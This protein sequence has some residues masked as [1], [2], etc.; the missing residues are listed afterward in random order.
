MTKTSTKTGTNRTGLLTSPID[1]QRLKEG[2]DK[3]VPSSQ[4]G[5]QELTE[6]HHDI[7]SEWPTLGSVPPPGSIKGA[8]KAAV[9]ALKGHG[10]AVF[11]DRLGERLAFERT[12]ARL[13]QA[14]IDKLDVIG[15]VDGHSHILDGLQ[16]IRDEELKHFDL[17]RRAIERLGA[18]P[19]AMTP[20]ADAS[21]VLG[22]G[23]LQLAGDPRAD[24]QQCLQALLVAELGDNDGWALLVE[25]AEGMDQGDLAEEFRRALAE[26]EEHLA[27]VRS[28]LTRAVLEDA[29]VIAPGEPERPGA[30]V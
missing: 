24:L 18:D 22:A 5:T 14:V 8:V 4:G 13:Y 3:T 15:E 9:Q 7:A 26:E 2:A 17:L 29:K 11:L 19:T 12:G 23:L 20:C 1:A 6:W 21:G 25:L 16:R 10:S 28:W 27:L 30:P